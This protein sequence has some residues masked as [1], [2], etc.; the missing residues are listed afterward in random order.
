MSYFNR[1][2]RHAVVQVL[3]QEESTQKVVLLKADSEPM[4]A[5]QQAADASQAAYAT[6]YSAPPPVQDQIK[7]HKAAANFHVQA[8]KGHR[9]S[10]KAAMQATPTVGAAHYQQ[11]QAHDRRAQDHASQAQYMQDQQDCG[12][13]N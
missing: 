2:L 10:G 9:T 13:A 12:Y 7:A 11:A 3:K 6:S 1:Q 8:A 5:S 4:Q